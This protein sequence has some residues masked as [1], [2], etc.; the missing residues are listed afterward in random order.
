MISKA[1]LLKPFYIESQGELYLM[2]E[3]GCIL[4][5]VTKRCGDEGVGWG[6]PRSRC[7]SVKDCKWPCPAV[8]L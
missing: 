8:L 4:T 1:N 6:A 2:R 3:C 5:F 7:M